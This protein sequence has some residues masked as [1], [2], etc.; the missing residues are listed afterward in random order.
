MESVAS[1][2]VLPVW[3]RERVCARRVRSYFVAGDSH[4]RV[5]NAQPADVGL[6]RLGIEYVMNTDVACAVTI[7]T[8]PPR[9]ALGGT[10]FGTTGFLRQA[11]ITK[12]LQDQIGR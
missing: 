6:P 11:G 3:W 9:R 12:P 4:G 1:S 10:G 7:P 5:L 2:Q 8:E